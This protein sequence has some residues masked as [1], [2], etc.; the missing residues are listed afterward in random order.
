VTAGTY[1]RYYSDAVE[2][3]AAFLRGVPVRVLNG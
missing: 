2:D 3:V 1:A